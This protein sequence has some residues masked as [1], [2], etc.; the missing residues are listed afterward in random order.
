M[1]R[2]LRYDDQFISIVND[3]IFIDFL[4]IFRVK[5]QSTCFYKSM[6]LQHGLIVCGIYDLIVG[7]LVLFY[8]NYLTSLITNNFLDK[9]EN[10]SIVAGILFSFMAFEGA[11]NLKKKLVYYY[12][13]YRNFITFFIPL[14]EIYFSPSGVCFYLPCDF[15]TLLSLM[16]I[17]LLVNL[18]LNK[19]VSSFYARLLVNQEL[20]IIHGKHLEKMMEQETYKIY[21]NASK[22]I[23]P[24]KISN[25]EKELIQ[26]STLGY[27]IEEDTFEPGKNPFLNAMKN[28]KM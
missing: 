1:A 17:Y 3:R 8:F 21:T 24:N 19:I 12:K 6:N 27:E 4:C 9:I 28:L 25:K 14:C 22:Y 23:P 5:A 7:S 16:F 11:I 26:L 2:P 10:G 13:L 15:F 18:Y 20:L